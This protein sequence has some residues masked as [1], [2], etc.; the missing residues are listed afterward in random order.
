M[1]RTFASV[2]FLCSA[3]FG[4]TPAARPEFDVAVIKLNKSG[5]AGP[6]TGGILPG[7]QISIRNAPLIVLLQMAYQ[8]K[9]PNYIVGG[10]GWFDSDR[11]DITAKAP[12]GTPE[13]QLAAMLQALLVQEFKL[14]ARQEQRPMDVFV[15]TVGKNGPKLQK[16]AGSGPPDCKRKLADAQAAKEGADRLFVQ[17]TF[18]AVCTNMTMAVLGDTLQGLAPGYVNRVV[19]DQTGL[20]G[21]YD[22][23]LDWAPRTLLDQGGLT[24]FDAVEKM[25]GLKLDSKKLPM[26]VVVIDHVERLSEN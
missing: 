12:P 17:G 9:R 5:D 4:Q 21:A 13:D 15:L 2:L 22:L 11:F 10:P 14:A 20:T 24:M 8:V 23:K 7:G 26:T 6:M 19:V 18:E 16:A 25:L 3:V 1:I